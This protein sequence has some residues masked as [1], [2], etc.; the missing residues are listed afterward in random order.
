[1]SG[2]WMRRLKSGASGV[3][4]TTGSVSLDLTR[5]EARCLLIVVK[6]REEEI[7]RRLTAMADAYSAIER[8][9]MEDFAEQL[10]RLRQAAE[11]ALATQ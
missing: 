7:A 6:Q 8:G 2:N 1:M 3:E 4:Y 11:R 10:R 9:T 5:A